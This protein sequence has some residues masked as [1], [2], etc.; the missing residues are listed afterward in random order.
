MLKTHKNLKERLFL[1]PSYMRYYNSIYSFEL[2]IELFNKPVKSHSTLCIQN[3][4]FKNYH[5]FNIFYS[6]FNQSLYNK[7]TQKKKRKQ[8]K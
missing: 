6:K 2:N 3:S 7:T 1:E 8:F 4:N 5:D